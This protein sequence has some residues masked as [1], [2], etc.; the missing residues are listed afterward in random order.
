MKILALETSGVAGS[1]ALADNDQT[2]IELL[3][4]PD[5]RSARTLAAAI[6]DALQNAGWQPSDIELVAVTV[7][8]GSFTGL[9]VGV[10]T[11]KTFA[12]A[13]GCR[14]VAVNTLETIAAAIATPDTDVATVI[15][16]QRNELFAAR[17][18]L[19]SLSADEHCRLDSLEETRIVSIDGWLASLKACDCVAGGGL[20][21]LIDKLPLDV[22]V[23]SKDLWQPRASHVAALG[24]QTYRTRGGDDPFSLVP[25]YI[26][27]TAAEEQWEKR[28]GNEVAE[29]L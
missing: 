27:R 23:A 5:Q 3:L 21:K 1:V 26:R 29:S 14:V 6:R 12:Y 2:L 15:D 16:A 13:V 8:P 18:R 10:V 25:Q 28:Q 17:W 19:G 22:V 24:L 4:P 11:A 20:E 7:G 9:R